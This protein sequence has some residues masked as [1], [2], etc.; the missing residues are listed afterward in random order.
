MALLQCRSNY[1]K[2]ASEVADETHSIIGYFASVMS[3]AVIFKIPEA[4]IDF[5]IA[6]H[7]GEQSTT[8]LVHLTASN[9]ATIS[10]SELV[11]A[12]K[13]HFKEEET[14]TFL[15]SGRSYFFEG[16]SVEDYKGKKVFRIIWGS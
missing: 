7:A 4:I 6:G 5:Q 8:D 15:Y 2:S 16:I 3:C 11:F 14:L 1:Y 10:F 13:S 12:I 9:G